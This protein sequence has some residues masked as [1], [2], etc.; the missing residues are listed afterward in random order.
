VWIL[1]RQHESKSRD[2]S[3]SCHLP[4]DQRLG[5][6]LFC[7]ALDRSVVGSNLTS[8]LVDDL[9][10]RRERRLELDGD[11]VAHFAGEAIRTRRRK[12]QSL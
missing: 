5:I 10:H 3:D 8:E 9:D 1:D 2:R 7:D 6:F 12:S 11:F 4:K